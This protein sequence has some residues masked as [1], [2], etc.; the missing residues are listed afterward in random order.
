MAEGSDGDKRMLLKLST[1]VKYAKVDYEG[2]EGCLE[3]RDLNDIGPWSL[4]LT[5]EMTLQCFIYG[6]TPSVHT[7]FFIQSK[8]PLY[9]NNATYCGGLNTSYS[10]SPQTP[11]CILGRPGPSAT[12]RNFPMM[13]HG[14]VP[15]VDSRRWTGGGCW[16]RLLHFG[17]ASSWKDP[18]NIGLG[19]SQLGLQALPPQ[20]L[21][22]VQ[23]YPLV[24]LRCADVLTSSQSQPRKPSWNVLNEANVWKKKNPEE[25]IVQCCQSQ[26]IWN[27]AGSGLKFSPVKDQYP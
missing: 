22:T 25:H 24:T 20:H 6:Q 21:S 23:R 16:V 9:H 2:L 13:K 4:P 11:C 3:L 19:I 18:V 12:P 14:V 27:P 5:T 7:R 26:D 15:E 10:Q 1:V 17:N 8:K